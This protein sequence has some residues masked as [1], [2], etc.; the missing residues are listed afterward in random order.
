MNRL[1]NTIKGVPRAAPILVAMALVV[2]VALVAATRDYLPAFDA[3]DYDRH[4]RSIAAGDGYPG[5]LFLLNQDSPSAFR[6]P[7]YPHILAAAYKLAPGTLTAGRLLGALLGSIAVLLIFLIVDRLWGR[8]AALAAATFAALFPPL[9]ALSGAL[10]AESLFIPVELGLALAVVTYS[11]SEGA[12]RWALLAGVLC[13][14][15]ALTRANGFLLALPLLLGLFAARRHTSVRSSLAASA[16]ALLAA[17]VVVM[18]W[19]IRNAVA[20]DGAFVPV[21]LTSGFALAGTYNEVA[22]LDETTKGAWR[23]PNGVPRDLP[24]FLRPDYD[25]LDIDRALARNARDYIREHPGY[26]LQVPLL[27]GY[28]LMNP[29]ASESVTRYS[30]EAMGIRPGARGIVSYSYF[31]L[32]TLA[33]FGAVI[34]ARR[35]MLSPLWLWSIP[36][37]LGLSFAA[38]SGEPRYRTTLDPFILMLAGFAVAEV[39]RH[40]RLRLGDAAAHKG[41]QHAHPVE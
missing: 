7:L 37:L 18:P 31:P 4:A 41:G 24:L 19:T 12:I 40:R 14:L 6:P 27:N 20:F 25:E 2:R 16:L 9:V 17:T 33:I 15:A 36:L 26:A 5:P 13:G 30:Y 21:S 3:I 22:R 28:R 34:A 10:T 38:L 39:V 29:A 35:R 8:V 32:A 23:P 11:R 1:R